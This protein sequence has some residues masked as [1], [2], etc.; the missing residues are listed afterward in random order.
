[1]RDDQ[2]LE[3]IAA[4][5]VDQAVREAAR[6]KDPN[7]GPRQPADLGVRLQQSENALDFVEEPTTEPGRL[8]FVD[9]GCVDLARELRGD[10][11]PTSSGQPPTGVCDRVGSGDGLR[12]TG[13]ELGGAALSLLKP[14][15]V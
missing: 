1:M 10:E 8:G 14:R 2:H 12:G 15:G 9:L 7:V 6:R 11:T 13:C 5:L 3:F 4:E